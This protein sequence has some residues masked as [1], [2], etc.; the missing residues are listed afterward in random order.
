M[1]LSGFDIG[2]NRSWSCWF[3]SAIGNT[4]TWKDIWISRLRIAALAE[5]ALLIRATNTE[6][7]WVRANHAMKSSV[8]KANEGV[9][10][11]FGQLNE[12]GVIESSL[13]L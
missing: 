10:L 6:E 3:Q 9:A 11:N 12:E 13:E 2:A 7:N 4:E 1:E 5:G 8:E